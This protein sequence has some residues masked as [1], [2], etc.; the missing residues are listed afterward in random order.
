MPHPLRST[1]W[2]LRV[3]DFLREIL[4]AVAFTISG[5]MEN[6]KK[7]SPV[8]IMGQTAPDLTQSSVPQEPR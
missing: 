4:K 3:N 2:D 6:T 1:Q 7:R 5:A 8:Y